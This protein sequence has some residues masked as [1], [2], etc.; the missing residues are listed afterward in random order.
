[1]RQASGRRTYIGRGG[2]DG[3]WT[4]AQQ[5][6]TPCRKYLQGRIHDPS[7]SAAKRVPILPCKQPLSPGLGCGARRNTA[8]NP[9]G[10]EQ[11]RTNASI[12]ILTSKQRDKGTTCTTGRRASRRRRRRS[13]QRAAP[14]DPRAPAPAPPRGQH[15]TCRVTI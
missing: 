5:E 6:G 7:F 10:R 8:A 2:R 4:R 9:H 13:D 3:G 15:L 1:M 11:G 14:G 12:L